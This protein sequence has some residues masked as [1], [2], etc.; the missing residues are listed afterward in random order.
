MKSVGQKVV[1]TLFGKDKALAKIKQ[2]R[3]TREG[4]NLEEIENAPILE[5]DLDTYSKNKEL[6]IYSSK[7][8][9]VQHQALVENV[10]VHLKIYQ[11]IT[12]RGA[13]YDLQTFQQ[14][15]SLN[16][17]LERAPKFRRGPIDLSLYPPENANTNF[18][19]F[20]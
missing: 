12:G 6:K 9:A 5:E 17:R 2:Q 19:K 14:P 10:K 11:N 3:M 4:C 16:I 8:D 15:K 20:L 13:D 1:H 18:V 7:D